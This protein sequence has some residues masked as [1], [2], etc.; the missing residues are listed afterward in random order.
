MAH[1][2]PDQETRL[3]RR[4]HRKA[5]TPNSLFTTAVGSATLETT[6]GRSDAVRVMADPHRVVTSRLTWHRPFALPAARTTPDDP[7]EVE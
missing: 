3:L 5:Q 4:P 1:R 6:K 7:N 2:G